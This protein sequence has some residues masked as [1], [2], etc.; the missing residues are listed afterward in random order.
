MQ[1]LA[2]LLNKPDLFIKEEILRQVYENPDT[3][4]IDFIKHILGIQH[5]PSKKERIE[6]EV[7]RFLQNHSSFSPAQRRFI[8]ALQSLL[9][10]QG[11]EQDQ[12]TF[13]LDHLIQAP[14]NRIGKIEDLFSTHELTETLQ[15]ANS[16]VA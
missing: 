4:L 14:F 13:T 6:A 2:V 8:Y 10:R 1:S 12:G 5:L 9:L 11:E 3:R 7:Q 16:Q 15:F